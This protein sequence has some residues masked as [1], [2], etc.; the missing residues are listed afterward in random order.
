MKSEVAAVRIQKNLRRCKARKDFKEIKSS[1]VVM[2][3]CLRGMASREYLRSRK[4]NK[5]AVMIQVIYFASCIGLYYLVSYS[6][7]SERMIESETSRPLGDVTV[8]SQI[9][10]GLRKHQLFRRADGGAEL[11]V[12]I[13]GKSRR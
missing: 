9:I 7:H 11:P 13:L 2:Q 4:Q 10:R 8:L 3:S 5:A 1:A 12:R 6:S